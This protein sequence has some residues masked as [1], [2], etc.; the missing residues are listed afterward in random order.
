MGSGLAA[1]AE[2]HRME[3]QR[4]WTV[5][6]ADGSDLS[7]NEYESGRREMAAGQYAGAIKHF[8]ISISHWPHFKSLELLG[9]SMLALGDALG[10]IVPLCCSGGAWHE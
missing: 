6:R 10:S 7:F 5:I 2:A 8:Q 3:H 1:R 9:E 4:R